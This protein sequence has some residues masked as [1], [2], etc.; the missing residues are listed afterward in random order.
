MTVQVESD[1]PI[2]TTTFDAKFAAFAVGRTRA[3]TRSSSATTSGCRDRTRRLGAEREEV[4]RKPPWAI[5]RAGRLVGLRGH[6]ARPGR[7]HAAPRGRVQRRP[8]ARRA[9]QPDAQRA[10][11]WRDGGLGLADACSPSDQ[12]VLARLLA[13]RDACF[14]H[15]GGLRAR[16]PGL[17]LRRATPTPASRRPWS[18]CGAGSASA[19]R[20]SATTATSCAAG[21]GL[22]RR[23]PGF[24][25]HGT[26]SHGDVPD[27]SSAGGAA[28]RHPLSRAGGGERDRAA[29]RPQADLA[30]PAGHAHQSRW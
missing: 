5:Y 27:V 11:W 3:P 14:L 30:A 28:A 9:L 12:I 26:W 17:R 1:L 13:D 16:R 7:P 2:T 23:P 19:P 20:S 15:S 8:H 25:V 4:Y 6:L 29:R 21:R 18:C 22:R 10:D 24:Y